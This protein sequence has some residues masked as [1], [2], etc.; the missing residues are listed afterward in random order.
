VNNFEDTYPE[1]KQ[2]NEEDTI[3]QSLIKNNDAVGRAN[4][5]SLLKS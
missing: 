5:V 2:I 1:K 3:K 4:P